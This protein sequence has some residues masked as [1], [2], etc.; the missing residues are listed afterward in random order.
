MNLNHLFDKKLAE[1][2]LMLCETET[3]VN[4][5]GN[6]SV[7]LK[8]LMR[9]E[10]LKE[11]FV[12]GAVKFEKRY[13]VMIRSGFLCMLIIPLVFLILMFS[14]NSKLVFLILWITSLVILCLY[15]I[16]LE[17]FHDKMIKQ[18]ALTGL[19]PE[20]LLERMKEKKKEIKQEKEEE[21]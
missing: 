12:N 8:V 17:Y 5:K 18:L 20:E 3:G 13:P 6:L 2:D 14:L 7:M 19:S 9:D 4:E 1:T 21:E 16:C 11:E 10:E 15:L